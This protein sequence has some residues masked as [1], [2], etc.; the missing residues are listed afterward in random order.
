MDGIRAGIPDCRELDL[1]PTE[2]VRTSGQRM[3]ATAPR[4][5]ARMLPGLEPGNFAESP[6]EE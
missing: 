2:M 4:V 6:E 1:E 3:N 5:F